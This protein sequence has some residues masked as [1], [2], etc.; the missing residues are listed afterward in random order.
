MSNLI[1]ERFVCNESELSNYNILE[2]KQDYCNERIVG[3][4][5]SNALH[6]KV[7]WSKGKSVWI[8]TVYLT[9]IVGGIITFS[10]ESFLV[11]I[12]STALTLCLGHSLGMH[13][14]LIHES[15]QC[16]K[17][18]E[19]LNVH[20]GVLVGLAGPRGM[21]LTHD[22]RD[23]A[24]RQSKCHDYFSHQQPMLND[25][26]W[27][28]HCEIE[29]D[30]PPVFAPEESF[31]NDKIYQF[32]EKYW[33]YQQLPWAIALF[34]IGGMP[35]VVWGVFMRVAVSVTGHWLIGYF[36]H[37]QG[38]R[39]WDV[40]GAAVQGF[41]IRFSSLITMGESWHNNHHAFP[42]SALLGIKD[43]QADPG[44]W[45]LKLFETFG[46]AWDLVVPND[47]PVRR[48]LRE[49]SHQDAIEDSLKE[50][51]EQ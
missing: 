32:M 23:W 3:T 37:N 48:E 12:I 40:D 18:L 50:L 51:Q 35:W 42:G 6:G 11:F 24:Q 39:D 44:W 33:M 22:M 7:I 46:L 5:N 26:F 41:N 31:D 21:M 43:G 20:L 14:K 29:L 13:R 1:K 47:L 2:R 4:E 19:Y 8:T 17:W 36:A 28:L 16:P 10:L 38:D 15:Y 34:A 27:Q 49:I 25:A 9:A 30:N 45:V